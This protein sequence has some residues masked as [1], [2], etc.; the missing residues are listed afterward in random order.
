MSYTQYVTMMSSGGG[1]S[2]FIKSA[3]PGKLRSSGCPKLEVIG[4]LKKNERGHKVWRI[5]V[6]GPGNSQEEE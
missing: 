2:V 1:K 3:V 5:G 4:R 6:G